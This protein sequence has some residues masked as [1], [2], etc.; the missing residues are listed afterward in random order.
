MMGVVKIVAVVPAVGR[1]RPPRRQ[2]ESALQY[3]ARRPGELQAL[4][5]S[6]D[7]ARMPVITDV[8]KKIRIGA[9]AIIIIIM[10]IMMV[11]GDSDTIIMIMHGDD[12]DHDDDD[13][14][15]HHHD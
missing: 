8:P 6:A 11:N 2:E 15:H 5:P 3:G 9:A 13:D 7:P 14:D 1:R 10:M 12:S 4:H